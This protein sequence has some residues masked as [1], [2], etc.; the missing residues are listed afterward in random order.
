MRLACRGD[1]ERNAPASWQNA[2]VDI[3]GESQSDIEQSG[4]EHSS[5]A[6]ENDCPTCH[7]SPFAPQVFDISLLGE[8]WVALLW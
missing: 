7:E 4:D 5:Y 3:W 2:L 8:L 6:D 1:I